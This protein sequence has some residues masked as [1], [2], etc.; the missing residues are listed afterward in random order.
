[1]KAQL[2]DLAKNIVAICRTPT[3]LSKQNLVRFERNVSEK[4]ATTTVH[5]I[6]EILKNLLEK[7]LEALNGMDLVKSILEQSDG[8]FLDDDLA[9]QQLHNLATTEDDKVHRAANFLLDLLQTP[10]FEATPKCEEARR[11]MY[12]FASSVRM[13]MPNA[14]L[15]E[16][17]KSLTTL[18]PFYNED[19]LYTKEEMTQRKGKQM[20]MIT[21][22]QKMHQQ[23]WKNLLERLGVACISDAWKKPGGEAEMR[24]WASGRGQTLARCVN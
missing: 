5:K 8:F 10:D 11:R 7:L 9:E 19:V 20:D 12:T 2:V 6:R 3:G 24:L 1:M 17:S 13:P 21:Y 18:T 4:L 23:E 22:L 15:A 16:E 14:P